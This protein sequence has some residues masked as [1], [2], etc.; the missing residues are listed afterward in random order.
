MRAAAVPHSVALPRTWGVCCVVLTNNM[1]P[2]LICKEIMPVSNAYNL[3]WHCMQKQDGTVKNLNKI[4][5]TSVN[6]NGFR[7]KSYLSDSKSNWKKN[8]IL[9]RNGKSV[10]QY[11]E[12]RADIVCWFNRKAFPKM[13]LSQHQ[14]AARWAEE[15]GNSLGK[16]WRVKTLLSKLCTGDG[17]KYWHYS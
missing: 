9:Y 10:K 17:W 6:S 8:S 7:H 13:S 4:F 1:T 3:I 15:T 16:N 5:F 12:S 2:C 11:V 14:P